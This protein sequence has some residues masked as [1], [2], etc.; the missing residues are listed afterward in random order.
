MRPFA[1]ERS[2]DAPAAIRA[3]AVSPG[4]SD[5]RAD[6]RATFLAGGTTLLDLMKLD[7]MRPEA[8]IDINTAV[9]RGLR[10]EGA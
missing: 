10:G 1:Y 5:K 6:G 3:A 9:M 8:L 4:A 7:V 2:P